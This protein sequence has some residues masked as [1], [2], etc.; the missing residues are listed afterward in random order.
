MVPG[1]VGDGLGMARHAWMEFGV[2]YGMWGCVWACRSVF[3]HRR[4]DWACGG[5][6]AL[7]TFK[8][9]FQGVCRAWRACRG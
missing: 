4:N 2:L 6:G 9:H 5:G 3:G 1:S 7:H 8:G